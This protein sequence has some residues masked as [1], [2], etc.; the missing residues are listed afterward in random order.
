MQRQDLKKARIEPL[1]FRSAGRHKRPNQPGFYRWLILL[2]G[3]L[4][5]VLLTVS[6]WY[7]FTARH[8]TIQI[9]PEPDQIAIDGSFI[10]PRL[11]GTFLLRPGRYVLRAVKECYRPLEEPFE[12]KDEPNRPVQFVMEKLPGR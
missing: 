10:A 4:I 2:T 3:G 9:E 11:A 5:F 8:V 7:V 12:V 1:A 6:A